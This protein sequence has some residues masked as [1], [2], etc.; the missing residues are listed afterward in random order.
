MN[1][2]QHMELYCA[3]GGICMKP[4]VSGQTINIDFTQA[5]RFYPTAY[6]SN[7]EITGAIFLDSLRKGD[8]LYTRLEYHN[9]VGTDYTI[10]NKAFR[11][12]RLTAPLSDTIDT[13]AA[14]ARLISR[15]RCQ[16]LKSGLNY[17][18]NRWLLTTSRS[19]FLFM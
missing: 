12:E 13:V 1:I 5:D 9:L 4:Y 8:Y 3:K 10:T 15:Y 7:S 11:S 14:Q 17:Q 19:L 18:R 6:N 16:R 2:S